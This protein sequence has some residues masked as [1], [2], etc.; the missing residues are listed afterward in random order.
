MYNVMLYNGNRH[1]ITHLL[2]YPEPTANPASN[3]PLVLGDDGTVSSPL[4]C[5]PNDVDGD[6]DRCTCVL[7]A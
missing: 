7:I 2:F 5:N 3:S 6:L 1:Q 4:N